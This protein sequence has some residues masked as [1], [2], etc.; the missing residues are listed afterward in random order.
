MHRVQ[1]Y[2]L[3]IDAATKQTIIVTEDSIVCDVSLD[4]PERIVEIMNQFF[5]LNRMAEEY[6]YMLGLNSA[7]EPIGVMQISHGNVSSAY[8]GV[9]ELLI[10]A[11]KMGAVR[12]IVVHNHPTGKRAPSEEDRMVFHKLIEGCRYIDVILSDFIIIAGDSFYSF[13]TE[14]EYND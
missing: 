11:L 10:R 8:L 2:N 5:G 13:L 7:M 14:K 6:V 1:T 3:Q 9:R 12:I 4:S